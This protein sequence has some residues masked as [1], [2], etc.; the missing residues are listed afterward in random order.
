MVLSSNPEKGRAI[1]CALIAVIWLIVG[2]PLTG[3]G[4]SS[5]HFAFLMPGLV[6]LVGALPWSIIAIV[7]FWTAGK[8]DKIV[9]GE[10][11]L[12]RWTYTKAEWDKA[13]IEGYT[14]DHVQRFAILITF[15][16]GIALF[17]ALALGLDPTNAALIEWGSAIVAVMLFLVIYY[18]KLRK[19]KKPERSDTFIARDGLLFNREFHLWNVFGA[20]FDSAVFVPK[21]HAIEIRYWFTANEWGMQLRT[22]MIPVPKGKEREAKRVVESLTKSYKS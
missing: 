16:V 5:K 8:Y 1:N 21:S 11:R 18:P 17:A 15:L 12:A 14:K 22:L 10:G 20:R 7:S 9:A 4:I 19:A 3:Y 2:V 13:I 6:L